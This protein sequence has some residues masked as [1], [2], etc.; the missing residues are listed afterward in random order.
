[1]LRYFLVTLELEVLELLW[2]QCCACCCGGSI[3]LDL[4]DLVGFGIS[5]EFV[6][7]DLCVLEREFLARDTVDGVPGIDFCEDVS[8]F[9]LLSHFHKYPRDA[10]TLPK[11]Q[12]LRGRDLGATDDGQIFADRLRRDGIELICR[13]QGSTTTCKKL[14]DDNIPCE[15]DDSDRNGFPE[16]SKSCPL[17]D[18]VGLC[19]CSGINDVLFHGI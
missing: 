18:D 1:M 9:D 19:L 15:C 14:R 8:F 2:S 3:L 12:I 6:I 10:S 11:G 17:S 4:L 5:I 7:V 13:R 16:E